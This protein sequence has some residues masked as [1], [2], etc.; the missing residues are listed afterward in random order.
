MEDSILVSVKSKIG[1]LDDYN[2]F[3]NDIIDYINS[4]FMILKQIGVGP[5]EGFS[6]D[7][8]TAKWSDFIPDPNRKAELQ[9]VKT[10]VYQKTKLIFDPPQSSALLESLKQSISEFEWRL[11]VEADTSDGES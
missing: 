1:M 6:I 8:E 11:N 7:D 9:G 4:V 10:Y 3:D 5:K 2:E